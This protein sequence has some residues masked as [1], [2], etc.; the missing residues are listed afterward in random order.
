MND[1]TTVTWLG[2]LAHDLRGPMG[3]LQ[4]AASMIAQPGLD[5][6]QKAELCNLVERQVSVLSQMVDELADWA[7]LSEDRLVD[8]LEDTDLEWM[9]INAVDSLDPALRSRVVLN[10]HVAANVEADASRLIQAFKA[11]IEA[12]AGLAQNESIPVTVDAITDG[13]VQI[14]FGNPTMAGEMLEK[15]MDVPTPEG[16]GLGLAL[17]IAS[18]IVAAHAGHVTWRADSGGKTMTMK[19]PAKTAS[20]V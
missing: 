2:R 10:A 20:R 6:T 13:E 8:R 11:L 9:L 14:V 5:D 4:M 7:S 12:R 1:N 16:K 17:P 19:L 18:A 3:P 15:S